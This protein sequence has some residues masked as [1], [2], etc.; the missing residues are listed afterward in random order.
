MGQPVTIRWDKFGNSGDS[1]VLFLYKGGN[2]TPSAIISNSTPNIGSFVWSPSTSL[3]TGSD[4][5]VQITSTNLR[6][7][8]DSG[9]IRVRQTS[10]ADAVTAPLAGASL[11]I[12]DR[13]VVKW[14]VPLHRTETVTVE[15]LRGDLGTS[16]IATGIRNTGRFDWSV[17]V[18]VPSG[19]AYKIRV[20]SADNSVSTT[21]ASPFSIAGILG[22]TRV[23]VPSAGSRYFGGSS[24]VVRWSMLNSEASRVQISLFKGDV[25]IKHLTSVG[26]PNSH[27]KA[28]RLP[29]NVVTGSDYRIVVDSQSSG[30][31]VSSGDFT[32]IAR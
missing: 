25:F 10:A 32:L 3:A 2:V 6:Y 22:E 12:R 18:G 4:Y 16:A 30:T 8:D 31:K 15:L 27:Q 19:D 17:G 20:R 28:V 29:G 26:Q 1:V 5:F 9:N 21:S 7:R 23:L 24:I 13:A 11:Q 14:D